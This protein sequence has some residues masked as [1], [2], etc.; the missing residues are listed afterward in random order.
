[1]K[2][3]IGFTVSTFDCLHAG[4]ILM[5]E[6]A[7]AQ[8]DYLIVGL[9]VDPTRDRDWK[10]KPVQSMFER[11][12]Q[13]KAVRYVDEIVPLDNEKDIFDCLVALQP[14]V[15]IVGEEYKGKVFTG[16]ELDISIYYNSR[17]HSYSS[18][19]IKQRIKDLTEVK[20]TQL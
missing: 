16:S 10:N 11:F 19:E 20:G 3:K 1:M 8:C 2:K 7:K 5:L 6:E 4:H 12:V 9:L 14:D 13:L 15:R 18:S 17:K